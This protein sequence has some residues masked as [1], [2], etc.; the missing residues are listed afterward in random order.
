MAHHLAGAVL[1]MDGIYTGWPII[2]VTAPDGGRSLWVAAVHPENAV[3]AVKA[4]VPWNY[5]ARLTIHRFAPSR[6]SD[7][8]RAGQVRRLRL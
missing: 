1:D 2:E 4:L 8:L 7:E 5:V 3:A 6:K